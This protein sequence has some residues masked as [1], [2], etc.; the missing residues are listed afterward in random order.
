MTFNVRNYHL[1]LSCRSSLCVCL[2]VF[3]VT[4]ETELCCGVLGEGLQDALDATAA[5][6]LMEHVNMT[7]LHFA[8]QQVVS[9]RC[10]LMMIVMLKTSWH[11]Q[12]GRL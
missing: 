4:L 2:C 9:D 12:T 11:D 7:K 5:A 3:L 10:L 6:T 8:L 1:D